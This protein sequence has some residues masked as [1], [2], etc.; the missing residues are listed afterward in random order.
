[1]NFIIRLL[2]TALV[3][4]GLSTL[5]SG[6]HIPDFKDALIF[7]LVLGVLNLFIRPLLVILTLPITIV[8]LGLFLFV[9]NALIILLADKLMDG[10]SIDSF[11]WALLFSLLLSAVSS[12]AG[13]LI[14]KKED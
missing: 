8:T 5:L 6:V 7:A 12:F 9:I 2:I 14:G 1:M 3:A 10:I 11:W 4:Y 13:S